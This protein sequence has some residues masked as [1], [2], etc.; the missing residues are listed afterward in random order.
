MVS[1]DAV[2]RTADEIIA[3]YKATRASDSA[4]PGRSQQEPPGQS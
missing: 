2:I 1:F 4:A 3:D